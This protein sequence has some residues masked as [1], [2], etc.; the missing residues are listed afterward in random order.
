M[1]YDEVFFGGKVL[2]CVVEKFPVIRKAQRKFSTFNVPGRNGDIIV[3]QDAFENV[4]V[5]YQV[6][7]GNGDVQAD[8]NDLAVVLYQKGYQTLQDIS[9]PEH[10][11]LGVFC[12]PVDAQYYWEQVGRTTLEFN[13]RPERFLL[14]G[15]IETEYLHL[16]DLGGNPITQYLDNPTAYI[17]K[18]LI[19]VVITA[20]GSGTITV[21]GNTLTITSIPE[22]SFFLDCET[23]DAYLGT[24][25][26]NS[27]VSGTFPTF[28]PGQNSLIIDGDISSI[29][30]THRWWE[31]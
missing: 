18:P 29:Y 26:L 15:T 8:W 11:R 31:L 2:P 23:Q 22:T 25:N 14:S 17:A 24:S 7:C 16:I 4:V 27:Y 21:N 30:V 3:Q 1:V 6:F 9:D 19:E 5:P 10:F 28:I 12:G 20:N 13:C